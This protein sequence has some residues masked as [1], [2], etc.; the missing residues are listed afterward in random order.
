MA[1]R[2]ERIF[3]SIGDNAGTDIS[4]RI[5]Q[6]CEPSSIQSI[7]AEIEKTC[8]A[9]KTA[10]I[11]EQCGRQCIPKSYMTRAKAV[12]AESKNTEDF[13]DKL[14]ETR[15][16]GGYLRLEEKKIIGI[17]K[18]CY[19]GLV[20]KIK[21]LSPLYCHCSA[22][23]YEQLFASV[24]DRPVKVEKIRSIKDGSDHCEFDIFI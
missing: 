12:Y 10:Q 6:N 21:G 20:K 23:W 17:Y 16:G 8:G 2:I 24:F 3:Q 14:N 18:E 9:E 1:S 5:R 22:G 11:M 7:L 19:C 4:A 13:L 15:I